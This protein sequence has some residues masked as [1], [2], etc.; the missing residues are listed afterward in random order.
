MQIPSVDE[1][2]GNESNHSHI[3]QGKQEQPSQGN[4]SQ[5]NDNTNSQPRE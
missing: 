2:K 3:E 5:V 1:A 4:Q